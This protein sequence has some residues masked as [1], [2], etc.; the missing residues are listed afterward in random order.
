MSI[1][2]KL[3]KSLDNIKGKEKV[4]IIYHSDADGISGASIVNYALR[5][6]GKNI[7]ANEYFSYGALDRGEALIKRGKKKKIQ[8]V[9]FV[10]LNM[11]S[12]PSDFEK[13]K[14]LKS[15]LLIDHHKNS[16]MKKRNV[17]IIKAD[18]FSKIPPNEYP[19][20][21]L[22]YDLF[23]KIIDIK[24]I[25]WKVIIGIYGDCADKRW[26]KFTNEEIKRGRYSLKDVLEIK[27]VVDSVEAIAPRKVNVVLKDLIRISRPEDFDFKKYLLIKNKFEKEIKKVEK[28]TI[29]NIEKHGDLWIMEMKTKYS[30]LKSH[31][32]NRLVRKYPKK[33][34]IIVAKNNGEVKISARCREGYNVRD[35]L[36]EAVEGLNVRTGGHI[37]AAGANMA[38]RNYRKYKRNLVRLFEG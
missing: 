15:I 18:E 30:G 36:K 24:E 10:D 6:M 7:V 16:H 31:V 9:I 5:K 26:K 19:A 33:V 14:F 28:D 21:K 20:S 3:K 38:R 37:P 32:I 22:S 8:H 23:S 12:E 25:G 1:I 34:L 4:S 29:K 13:L 35:L 2:K 11:D 27:K 17:I